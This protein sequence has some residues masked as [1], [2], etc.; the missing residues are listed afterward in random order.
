MNLLLGLTKLQ[1]FRISSNGEEKGESC[2]G[3]EEYYEGLSIMYMRS[4]NVT[5]VEPL[6][7]DTLNKGHLCLKDTLQY[8]VAIHFTSERGQHLYNGRKLMICVRYL[9][10]P[11]YMYMNIHCML[12][13]TCNMSV[14]YCR[15]HL[16]WDCVLSIQL[17]MLFSFNLLYLGGTPLLRIK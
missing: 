16:Q 3:G 17:F 6:I 1:G 11:L 14:S 7:K 5:I 12:R 4:I 15:Q 9:E 10:V 2:L 13:T 8:I